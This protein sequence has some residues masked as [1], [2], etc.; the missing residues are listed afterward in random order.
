VKDCTAAYLHQSSLPEKCPAGTY[1]YLEVSD[2]GCGMDEET[3]SRLFDPFYTTKFIGR[4]LG[5]A[6]VLG[7]VRGHRGAILVESEKG[8]GAAFRLLFPAAGAAGGKGGCPE[9]GPA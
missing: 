4:G 5:L 1:V 8:R 7:I 6:A 3:K 2:D 9:A